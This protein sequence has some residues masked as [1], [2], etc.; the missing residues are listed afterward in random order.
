MPDLAAHQ[1]LSNIRKYDY[2]VCGESF[3]SASALN[4]HLK[5]CSLPDTTAYRSRLQ[6]ENTHHT[7][8]TNPVNQKKALGG[9]FRVIS[10]NPPEDIGNM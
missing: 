10:L 5:K 3:L 7:L 6:A 2:V 8:G 4:S 1:K 9:L